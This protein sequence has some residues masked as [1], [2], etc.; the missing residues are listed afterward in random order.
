[1][2]KTLIISL[3]FPPQVGGV[4]TYVHDLADALDEKKVVVLA[5][6]GIDEF[7]SAKEKSNWDLKQKY[8][9]IRKKLL[10]PKFIWPRWLILLW[11][12]FW[13]VKKEKIEMV[14]VQHVLP[15]GY[16]AIFVKKFLKVPFLLFSHGTDLI[17]GTA[18][19]WK[20][21]MVTIVSN[22]AE[23]IIFN[24]NSLQNRFL[25]VLTQFEKKSTVLYPCPEPIF[26]QSPSTEEIN[27]IKRRYAL[28]GKQTMLSVSRLDEGKGFLHLIRYM[29]KILKECP[30][31]VWLII[32]SGPK[33]DVII[34]SIQKNN[35][36]NIVR[37]IG[38]VPHDQLQPF[39]YISDMFVLLTHPDEGREE[40]LGLVFLEA[41]A[42]GLP[43][44]AGRSGGVPEAV[45]DKKTGLVVETTN[46]KQVV[47][48]VAKLLNDSEYARTLGNNAKDRMVRDFSWPKQIELLRPWIE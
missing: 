42:V 29:P 8:K 11:N 22:H 2:K 32:G 17:A 43:I 1:M 5:P 28:E 24:S 3:E 25:R 30:N 47:D 46:E 35:L 9:I 41:S 31:I 45:L 6:S 16:A 36:Q 39:F 21:K 44:V 13:V 33:K 19:P 10:F 12:V 14:F 7:T 18:T 37:F 15:V 4:A 23:Q 20:R 38:E 40:G 27:S 34:E 26:L 48:S